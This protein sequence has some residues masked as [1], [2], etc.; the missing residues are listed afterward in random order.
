MQHYYVKSTI[1]MID[2]ETFKSQCTTLKCH[3]HLHAS[4]LKVNAVTKNRLKLSF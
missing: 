3:L 1:V 2:D 4:N